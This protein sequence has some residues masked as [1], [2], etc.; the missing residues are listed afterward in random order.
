MI[1][2]HSVLQLILE[3]TEKKRTSHLEHRFEHLVLYRVVI[4]C[5]EK[6]T[7]LET[8]VKEKV[9]MGRERGVWGSADSIRSG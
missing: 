7:V 6:R 8:S 4:D 2:V 5:P 1:D 3:S 9:D